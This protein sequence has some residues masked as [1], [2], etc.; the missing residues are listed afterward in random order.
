MSIGALDEVWVT[1][2][3]FERQAGQVSVGAEVTMT[4][5]YLP[6]K[7]WS[8]QVD[9]I[10][11]TLDAKTRTVR[12]RLRF[13]NPQNQ[14]KPNMFAQVAIHTKNVDAAL[15]VPHEAVIR[16]GSQDRVVLAMGDG[17]YKSIE[18]R[19]GHSSGQ[20]FEVL[21]GLA[22]GD[23]VVTSAHFLLDSESSINADFKRMQHDRMDV[24]VSNKEHSGVEMGRQST[25]KQ[26]H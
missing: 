12:L 19:L 13:A 3:L 23:N 2:E 25:S 9:Y 24:P 6:G 4:L 17:K 8:G 1:A 7:E 18:V 14:L 10:Y 11:P 26:K 5:D 15:L 22:E 20:F 21:E 16:T